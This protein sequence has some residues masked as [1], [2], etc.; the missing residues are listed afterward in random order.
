MVAAGG[1]TFTVNGASPTDLVEKD[2]V[3]IGP[4]GEGKDFMLEVEMIDQA[5]LFQ[6][7]GE[8]LGRFF[9]FKS[10]DKLHAHQIFNAYFHR[11]AAADRTAVVAESFAVLDPGHRAVDV[12][13]VP[14]LFLH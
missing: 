13:M 6:S 12:A 11:Q 10:I 9:G 2:A 14:D 7:F 3:V 5:G 4:S 8:L 1:G